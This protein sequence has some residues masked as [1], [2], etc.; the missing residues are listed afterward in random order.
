MVVVSGRVRISSVS[1]EGREVILN[2]IHP[3]Q[4]FGEVAFLDGS[5]RTADATALETSRLLV[6]HRR[7]FQPFLRERVELCL[8]VM[9]LLCQRL[10]HTTEQVE[11]LALRSLE[12]RLARVL[13]ALA[14]ST[15]ERD[16]AGSVTVR[17][18]LS[19]RELGEITG[20]T[21]ESVNKTLRHWRENG[22]AEMHEKQF[23][24]NDLEEFRDLVDHF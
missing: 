17:T 22:I 21:R 14:E 4:T 7:D 13:L 1:I 19:Q 12:S 11:D 6:L 16:S 2:E 10:R 18:S 9:K 5:D 24:I 8:E 15:G 3:G 23:H 20:A